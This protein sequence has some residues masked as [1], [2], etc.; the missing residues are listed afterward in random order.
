MVAGVSTYGGRMTFADTAD[1]AAYREHVRVRLQEAEVVAELASMR[2]SGA[3]EPDERPLYRLLGDRGLLGVDWPVR[4]GGQGRTAVHTAIAV[5]EM[6]RAGVPDTVYVNSIQTTGTLVLL[7]GTEE[8]RQRVLRPLAEGRRFA[9]VLYTEPE[10]GSDLSSLTT[11]ATPDG[12]GYRL[13]GVKIFNL[14]SGITDLGLCAA[15]TRAGGSR[16][17]GITLFLV[18]MR[19]PGVRAEPLDTS[20]DECFYRVELDDVPVSGNDVLGRPGDGWALLSEALPLER[21]GFDFA[22]RA[23]R[24]YA[25]ACA[26]L[27]GDPEAADDWLADV[28]RHGAATD[29]ARLLAWSCVGGADPVQTSMAKWYASEQAS[30]V[31]RWASVCHGGTAP[32]GL[33]RIL[34]TAYREAPGLTLS[35]GTSEIMLHT[36]AASLLAGAGVNPDS[37]LGT[38]A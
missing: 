4:Y 15:R 12:N 3:R 17:E 6:M 31:A 14:K 9:C 38:A 1:E 28:G 30:A 35:G 21:T 24:W 2:E 25:A 7:A 13:R 29:A 37:D 5:E 18:D 16:Y 20:A 32:P 8:Q 36:L 27:Q 26:G 19:A 22:L 34:D 11:T 10:V 23:E 33:A